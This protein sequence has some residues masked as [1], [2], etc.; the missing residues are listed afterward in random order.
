MISMFYHV[1]VF[2]FLGIHK[3]VVLYDNLAVPGSPFAVDV[4]KP[5][6]YV[7]DMKT[8]AAVG[9]HISESTCYVI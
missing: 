5:T 9:Q 6:M 1:I 4:K 7:R 8:N 2:F 3:L